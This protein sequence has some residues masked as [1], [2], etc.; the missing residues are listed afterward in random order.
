[1][2][3]LIFDLE[4]QYLAD[5]VGGWDHIAKMK[6]AC[7]VTCNCD[8]QQFTRYREADVEQLLANLHAATLVVGF[9]IQRFD[10]EVLRPY[11]GGQALQLPTV[12]LLL[13]IYNTL[14]F[15]LSL[16]AVASATLSHTKSADGILA[17]RWFRQGEI[18]KILDYCQQDVQ[19]TLDLYRFGQ[20]NK[21]V[22]YRD[23]FGR[24]KLVP[25]RW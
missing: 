25:V 19:V 16:D 10:Y 12:D 21:H 11:A 15:R 5:E 17:V 8:T 22:K 20:Q 2:S 3:T 4:T 23:K 9:N 1:V 14:G 7:A 13:D 24:V 6:L 18:E